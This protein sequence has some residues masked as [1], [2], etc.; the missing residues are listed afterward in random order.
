MLQLR[1]CI[2]QREVKC[3]VKAEVIKRKVRGTDASR[4]TRYSLPLEVLRIQLPLPK[5]L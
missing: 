4:A 5:R 2:G 3:P 1:V